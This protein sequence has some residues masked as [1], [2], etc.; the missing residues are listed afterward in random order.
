[1][2]ALLMFVEDRLVRK[3]RISPFVVFVLVSE[4]RGKER[5]ERESRRKL[6]AV[7]VIVVA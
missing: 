3:A 5:K 1:M 7:V 6:D 4:R 2:G